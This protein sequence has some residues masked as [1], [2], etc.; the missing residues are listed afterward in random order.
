MSYGLGEAYD[1]LDHISNFSY[2][3]FSRKILQETSFYWSVFFS[4]QIYA[5]CVYAC[6]EQESGGDAMDS[7]DAASDNTEPAGENNLDSVMWM[8]LAVTTN[9]GWD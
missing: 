4:R 5:H 1:C 2:W 7:D 9:S 3:L 8:T 6:L